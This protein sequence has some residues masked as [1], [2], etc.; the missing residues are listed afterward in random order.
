MIARIFFRQET[1]DW[2]LQS[3]SHRDNVLKAD[4]AYAG[5]GYCFIADDRNH[6]HHY[7]VQV[8]GTS[9]PESGN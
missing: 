6:F 3:A 2:W 7:R 5:F 1:L 4:F 8:L 9:L